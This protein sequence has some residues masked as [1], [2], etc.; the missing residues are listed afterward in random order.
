M[1]IRQG[2]TRSIVIGVRELQELA[3]RVSRS[4]DA[5]MHVLLDAI[6]QQ[7]EDSA[8]RRIGETKKAPDGSKWP[9]WSKRYART[10]PAGKSL[11]QNEGDLLDSMTHVVDGKDAVEVGS[12]L[13]YAAIHLFGDDESNIPSRAYLDTEPGFADPHDRSELRDIVR[14]FMGGLL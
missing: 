10:R 5:E 1:A 3:A 6:G 12:N 13:V 9:A 14:D 4:T 2:D 11:L 7:Q 8:R